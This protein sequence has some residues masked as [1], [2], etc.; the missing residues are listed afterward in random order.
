MPDYNL[1]SNQQ[2]VHERE[3]TSSGS[4]TPPKLA[5]TDVDNLPQCTLPE[6]PDSSRIR[7]ASIPDFIPFQSV[8]SKASSG[9]SDSKKNNFV[10]G[11][12]QQIVKVDSFHLLER[13]TRASN[14][15]ICSTMYLN[16]TM[17]KRYA[18]NLKMQGIP[19]LYE[20]PDGDA[21]V[22]NAIS[23][24][25]KRTGRPFDEIVG[26][27][28]DLVERISSR[29]ARG[30]SSSTPDLNQLAMVDAVRLIMFKGDF[31]QAETFEFLARSVP[32]AEIKSKFDTNRMRLAKFKLP[33]LDSLPEGPDKNERIDRAINWMEKTIGGGLE[34][35]LFLHRAIKKG[36]D[37]H[38]LNAGKSNSTSAQIPGIPGSGLLLPGEKELAGKISRELTNH[39]E[40][41]I[42]LKHEILDFLR[43]YPRHNLSAERSGFLR[44]CRLTEEQIVAWELDR[45]KEASVVGK[46]DNILQA[47]SSRSQDFVPQAEGREGAA[48]NAFPGSKEKLEV[49]ADRARRGVPLWEKGDKVYEEGFFDPSEEDAIMRGAVWIPSHELPD[50]EE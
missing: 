49:L 9:K 42:L 5:E 33:S 21:R 12:S 4:N 14:S 37:E 10:A 36:K 6:S 1:S 45:P 32:F 28:L 29:R 11:I 19:V 50:S 3:K 18:L 31:S 44:R 2:N 46:Y 23:Y 38:I 22:Q 39:H 20:A 17:Y 47:I 13:M 25:E 48:T 24:L 43:R 35:M 40:L 41:R 8:P 16:S 26:G 15:S 34:E 27:L 30:T 7:S